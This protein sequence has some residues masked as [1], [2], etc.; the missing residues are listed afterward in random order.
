MQKLKDV[1][2]EKNIAVGYIYFYV[3]M[4]TEILCFF[5]LSKIFGSKAI[6][7]MMPLVY[8][9]VAFM[10]QGIIGYISDKYPKIQIGV[11]GLILIILGVILCSNNLN[12]ISLIVLCMGNAFL[13]VDAA[14]VTLR[15]SDGKLSHSAIFVAGGSFGVILGKILG[16]TTISYIWICLIGLTMLP[17]ILLGNEYRKDNEKPCTKFNYQNVKISPWIVVL[18]ATLIVIARGYMGY[19]IPQSW[20]KTL[21]QSILLYTIMGFGKALGGILC[22]YIGMKKVAILSML[23]AVPFLIVGDNIMIISLIG[24]MFFSM[25]MAVTLGLL[26]SALK[27]APGLAFGLTTVGLFLGT[28]PVFF[29]RIKTGLINSIMITTLSIIC[30]IMAFIIIRKDKNHG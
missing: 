3:H 14:E 15:A 25:T 10:P 6:L 4:V 26:T 22:D 19:G 5:I 18:L 16:A 12:Y 11:I 17:F 27:N 28:V 21:V 9:A 13:H 7:W 20:N 29:I 8:D 30:C 2:C 24:V 23:I 1:L